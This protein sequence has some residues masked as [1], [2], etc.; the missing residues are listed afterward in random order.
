MIN[1]LFQTFSVLFTFA[2]L[3]E[4]LLGQLSVKALVAS[5]TNTSALLQA[6]LNSTNVSTTDLP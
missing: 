6:V 1:L 4:E 3:L 2:I 5:A